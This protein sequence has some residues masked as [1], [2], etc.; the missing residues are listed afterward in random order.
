MEE[1]GDEDEDEDEDDTTLRKEVH[2][3]FKL[4]V[5][6][7]SDLQTR[8]TRENTDLPQ[9]MYSTAPEIVECH[10]SHQCHPLHQ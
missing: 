4:L 3:A 8:A 10:L 5:P 2:L 7:T 6:P 1:L 9:F